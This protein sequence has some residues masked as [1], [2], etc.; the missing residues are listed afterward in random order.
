M[1]IKR[2]EGIIFV[3]NEEIFK[4]AITQGSYDE[5]FSDRLG[6]DLGHLTPKGNRLLAENIA[7]EILRVR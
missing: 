1:L 2:P 4:Q 3:D 6:G 5:Y 7:N